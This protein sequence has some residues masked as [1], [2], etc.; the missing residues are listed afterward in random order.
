[1]ASAHS[2][3]TLNKIG[4][5]LSGGGVR[6]IAHLGAIQALNEFGIKPDMI[7]GTSAGAIIG[8]FIAEGYEPWEII[9]I[10]RNTELFS[11]RSIVFGKPGLL[12]MN[13][14]KHIYAR[15]ISHNSFR[16]LQLPLYVTATDI[17]HGRSIIFDSGNLDEA[18]MASS[19]VPLV[20]EP[21][22]INGTTLIDGGVLNNFPVE[23]LIEKCRSIIGVHVNSINTSETEIGMMSLVDRSFHLALGSSVKSKEHFCNLFIEPEN[24]TRFGMFD[25]KKMDDIFDAGY[26]HVMNMRTEVEEFRYSVS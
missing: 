13:S 12:S 16:Q 10:A 4:L 17:I 9:D 26:H 23:P 24:M 2:D 15:Y 1:M 19:C 21:V 14:F 6:G 5:V 8:A 11:A 18:L 3:Q 22:H 25:T 7:S 20:F